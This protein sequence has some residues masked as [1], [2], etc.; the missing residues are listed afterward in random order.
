M[1]AI[2]R[3]VL[4]PVITN[5]HASWVKYCPDGVVELLYSG[6]NDLQR[7]TLYAPVTAERRAASFGAKPLAEPIMTLFSPKTRHHIQAAAI[8]SAACPLEC[9]RSA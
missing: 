1:H 3:L 8:G 5:I 2:S 6:V 9:C 4:H 7:T